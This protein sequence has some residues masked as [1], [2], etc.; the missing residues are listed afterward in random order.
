MMKNSTWEDADQPLE[1]VVPPLAVID[2]NDPVAS[3][4]SSDIDVP[5]ILL[6]SP[7]QFIY[8]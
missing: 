1:V 6:W 2:I 4:S 5:G 8:T 7:V 3:V